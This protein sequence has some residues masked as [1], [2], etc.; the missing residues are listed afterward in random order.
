MNY[1]MVAYLL[2]RIL[3][4]MGCLMCL[5]TVIALVLHENTSFGFVLSVVLQLLLGGICTM[6]KPEHRE[7]YA[8]EG[9]VIVAGV[10]MLTSLF[11]AIPFYASREIPSFVDA[12]F[13]M[14]S[15]FTTTGASILNDIESLS[16]STLFWRSF[17]HWIGGMGVLVFVMA[18]LPKEHVSQSIHIM[19]AEVPGPQAGKLVARMRGTAR[20]LY[21][22]YIAVT[23]VEVGCLMLA[24]L[25]FFDSLLNSFSTAGTGGFAIKNASIAAYD[26][27]AVDVIITV[28]MALF[29]INFSLF[30]LLLT[31]NF[32]Q[33]FKDEELRWYIGIVLVSMLVVGI[34]IMPQYQNFFE[35]LRYSAFQVVSI[36][37]TTGFIT[38]DYTKWPMLS[39]TILMLLLFMGACAGSTGGGFKV[40]RLII[41][42]KSSVSEVRRQLRPRTVAPV[43][44]GGKILDEKVVGSVLAYLCI[45]IVVF[46][47]S[48][49]LLSL[50]TFSYATNF[51]AVATCINNVGPGLE[52]VG[53]VNNFSGFSAFSKLVLSFDMLA[54]RLELVPMVVLFAPSTWKRR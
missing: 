4:I 44:L 32:V 14:V 18:V 12:F 48:H 16:Y 31:K 7:I 11:G 2:G 23:L 39:Q 53:P 5:P 10:W 33:V 45:Y 24:G 43:R 36:V 22:I 13:E 50:D 19:R 25:P 37:T 51:A 6:K 40:S 29:G 38:A 28:F 3:I 1:K 20:I 49:L 15:G 42:C 8:K 34:N 41:L 9:F 47:I 35:A 52:A 26:S 30:Y 27:V 21:G 17:S 54:G 46:I